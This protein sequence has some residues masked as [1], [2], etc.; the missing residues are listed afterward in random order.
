MTFLTNL[1]SYP[2]ALLNKMC[3]VIMEHSLSI[4][5]H[6][7]SSK[8]NNNIVKSI[9]LPSLPDDILYIIKKDLDFASTIALRSA[10]RQLYSVFPDPLLFSEIIL[11]STFTQQQFNNLISYLVSTNKNKYIRNLT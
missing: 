10:C 4:K 2:F 11:L 9:F 3:C 7:L 1:T 6:I 5:P 8:K